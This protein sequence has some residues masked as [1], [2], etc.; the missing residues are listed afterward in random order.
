MHCQEWI[1]LIAQS[2]PAFAVLYVSPHPLPCLPV[3]CLQSEFAAGVAELAK[4][5]LEKPKRLSELAGRWWGEIYAG[6]CVFDRQA[7]E[8]EVLR[9]LSPAELAAFS[10]EVLGVSKGVRRK[11]VVLIRGSNELQQQQQQDGAAAAAAEGGVGQGSCPADGEQQS[12]AAAAAAAAEAPGGATCPAGA[13]ANG[14]A[15]DGVCSAAAPPAAAGDDVTSYA[16]SAVPAGEPFLLIEDI[17]AFKRGCEVYP[18]AGQ[19]H[20]S[21]KRRSVLLGKGAAAAAAEAGAT[22]AAAAAA[23]SEDVAPSKL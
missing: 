15:A 13:L 17:N 6:T 3:L 4:A 10:E 1:L 12:Q 7:A 16:A 8:V 11:A 21:S 18:A 20:G 5:K 14:S 2:K 22:G 23:N 19:Q 9:G